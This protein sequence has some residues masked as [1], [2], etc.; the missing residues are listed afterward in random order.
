G[1]GLGGGLAGRFAESPREHV[2]QFYP[3]EE[4]LAIPVGRDLAEGIGAGNGG[5]V[6]ATAAHRQAFAAS[7]AAEGVDAGLEQRA[8]R[9]LM[10]DASALLGRLLDPRRVAP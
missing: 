1:S 5:L 3:A 6:V 8:G 2:V 7:L 10:A 4:G 9:L